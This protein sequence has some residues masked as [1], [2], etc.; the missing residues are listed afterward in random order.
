MFI[1][2]Y[3]GL[4][5]ECKPSPKKAFVYAWS[6]WSPIG[7]VSSKYQATTMLRVV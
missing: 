7:K 2:I 3:S 5:N 4:Y 1:P 6:S